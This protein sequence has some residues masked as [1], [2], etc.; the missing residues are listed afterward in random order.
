MQLHTLTKKT[1]NK[2]KKIVGRGGKRG[3]YSG[4]GQKGQKARAGRKIRP[5]VRDMLKKIPKRRGYG[6]N[7][8]RTVNPT[9]KKP[10]V[11]NVGDL[12]IFKDIVVNPEVLLKNK[13]VKRI[14]GNIP[15]VKILGKGSITIPI[16]V[17]GCFVSDSA[18]E[19]IIKSGGVI[20]EIK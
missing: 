17:E 9:N 12:M 2:K 13:L 5:E 20:K 4:K 1:K 15:E 3:T 16:K 10:Q 18:K 11:V 7:R 14:G 8:S 19:K 6:K